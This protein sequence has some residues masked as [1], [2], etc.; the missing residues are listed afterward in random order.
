MLLQPYLRRSTIVVI[1][2]VSHWNPISTSTKS[3][4][5]KYKRKN[6]ISSFFVVAVTGYLIQYSQKYR[7]AF[8]FPSQMIFL[9]PRQTPYYLSCYLP[10]INWNVW[11][12]K[13]NRN[14]K[15]KN[16]SELKSKKWTRRATKRCLK[17]DAGKSIANCCLPRNYAW[18]SIQSPTLQFFVLV[19]YNSVF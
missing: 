8:F 1:F 12:L 4:W 11:H 14:W 5:I 2:T 7:C 3:N 9:N 18:K 19:L 10:K 13:S 15:K 16:K 6:V 17:N